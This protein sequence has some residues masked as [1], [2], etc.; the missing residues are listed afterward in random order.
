MENPAICL[1]SVN[2][3]EHIGCLNATHC[4]NLFKLIGEDTDVA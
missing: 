4:L 2:R 3:L 1:N